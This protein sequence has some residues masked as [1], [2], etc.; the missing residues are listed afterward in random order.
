MY[1]HTSICLSFYLGSAFKYA[2]NIERNVFCSLLVEVDEVM[3]SLQ[4]G[5]IKARALRQY[6][7]RVIRN[8]QS[9]LS[10]FATSSNVNRSKDNAP[11]ARC[12]PCTPGSLTFGTQ[13]QLRTTFRVFCRTLPS[14][15][16]EPVRK[17]CVPPSVGGDV[18]SIAQ[19][20]NRSKDALP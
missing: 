16:G 19:C 15:P 7:L 18:K 12:W 5:R 11:K 2:I 4:R 1:R 10:V 9:T 6:A 13:G 8:G 3:E 20:N 14:A 17:M